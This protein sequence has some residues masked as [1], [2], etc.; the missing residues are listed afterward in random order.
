M[1]KRKPAKSKQPRSKVAAKAQRARQAV[2]RSPKP[3]HVRPVAT[4]SNES[5]PKLLGDPTPEAPVLESPLVALV[6][7]ENPAIASGNEGQRTMR[8]NDLT[9][10]FDVSSAPT[11][12][13]AYQRKLPEI[14]QA[15]LQL[16]FEFIQRLA[17]VKSPFEIPR[18]VAELTTKQL[19][20]FQ[21]F[22][23]AGQSSR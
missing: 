2:V 19:A 8:D 10:A 14:A 13:W 7:V 4:A 22:V 12:I 9:R 11:T 23:F 17:S 20:M 15:N 1:S 21:S 6:G 5:L 16:A 3:R 18:V